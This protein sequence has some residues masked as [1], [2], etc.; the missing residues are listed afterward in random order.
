[1]VAA[2]KDL[3]VAQH[4]ANT[5][6]WGAKCLLPSSTLIARHG[7]SNSAWLIDSSTFQQA[8]MRM[9]K[10]TQVIQRKAE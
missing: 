2:R 10:P 3:K 5:L 8:S 6:P 1:M 7:F 4:M 9:L